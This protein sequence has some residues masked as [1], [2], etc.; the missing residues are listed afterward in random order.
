MVDTP[1]NAADKGVEPQGMLRLVCRVLNRDKNRQWPKGFVAVSHG[2]LWGWQWCRYE[3]ERPFMPV[4]GCIGIS[5]WA[6]HLVVT[7]WHSAISDWQDARTDLVLCP[8]IAHLGR[9]SPLW[10]FEKPRVDIAVSCIL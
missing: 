4:S 6:G 7:K 3:R 2:R 5:R 8:T 9:F 10:V 1:W